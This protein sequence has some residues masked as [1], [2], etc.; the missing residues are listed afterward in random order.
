MPV[1]AG[2]HKDAW[3]E[4]ARRSS[5][6]QIAAV[7]RPLRVAAETARASAA[8]STSSTYYYVIVVTVLVV[9]VAPPSPSQ[10]PHTA[11]Q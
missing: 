11:A 10:A 1:A 6:L 8:A 4:Y 5:L 3:C 7:V 2:S 9:L